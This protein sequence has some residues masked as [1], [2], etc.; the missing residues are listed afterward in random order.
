MVYSFELIK[1]ANIRYRESL[2]ALARC[3]LFAMLF[4]LGI[5]CDISP[6]SMGGSVF[7]TFECR[8]LTEKELSFLSGH[9]S[10]VF[11]AEKKGGFLRPLS[12]PSAA[13][14]PDDLPEV[15]KYKGKTGV[16]FTRMMINTAAAISFF[17]DPDHPLTFFDPLCGKGTGCFCALTAGMNAVGID[18]D[19]KDIR[20]AADYFSRYLQFHKLKHEIKNRSE[21][22]SKQ[23]VP[24]TTFSFAATKED[25][26]SGNVRTLTLACADTAESPALFRRNK[27]HIIAAD[28]PYGIQHAPQAGARPESMQRFL[29]RILPAWKQALR[30]GG[31]IAVSFNTLTLPA[32]QV[33]QALVASGFRLPKN[34]LFWCLRHDV[35]HAVVRDVVFALNTEEES[36]I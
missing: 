5:S 20:E 34:E 29:A 21:T 23:A 11:I 10:V 12:A 32:D 4:S 2:P 26:Q 19:R 7:L 35:E 36:V 30:P 9:S 25:F 16:T 27:A 22:V 17:H 8:E 1:H 15:L 28:L 6:E 18:V 14:L 13:R 31:A 24:V 33:K 3:E